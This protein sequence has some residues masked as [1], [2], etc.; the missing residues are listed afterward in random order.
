[1]KLRLQ[2]M[3]EHMNILDTDAV[4]VPSDGPAVVETVF[5][6][7]YLSVH[8]IPNLPDYRQEIAILAET[9]MEIEKHD[10]D[11]D[12]RYSA[13]LM[14][15]VYAHMVGYKTGI[16]IDPK[17]PDWPVVYIELPTGQ[18]SWHMPAHPVAYDG[19]TT[20]EKYQRIQTFVSALRKGGIDV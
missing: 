9:L 3:T 12:I 1:M 14:A 7:Y 16:A 19:H 15:M 4:E 13:V 10:Q 20:D 5:G 18:V 6:S 8:P 17:E 2:W 11:Y